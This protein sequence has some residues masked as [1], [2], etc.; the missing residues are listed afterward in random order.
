MRVQYTK[1]WDLACGKKRG[2]KGI[3]KIAKKKKDN[4]WKEGM[5]EGGVRRSKNVKDERRRKVEKEFCLCANF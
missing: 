3:K 5:K 4:L 2:E 1:S